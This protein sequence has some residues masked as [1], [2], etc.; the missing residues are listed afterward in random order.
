LEKA[1]NPIRNRILR[2]V[3]IRAGE[4]VPHELNP[5][6]HTDTQRQALE[7][8]YAEI[9]FARSLLAYPLADG[10]LKLIDG[11]LR[12]S[13]NPDQEVDVEVLDVND[14][15]AR[16]LLLAIDPLAQIAGYDA[17][18][19]VQLRKAA[20]ADSAAIT[21]LFQAVAEASRQTGRALKEIKEH[22]ELPEKFYVL[23]DCEDEAHQQELLIRFEKEGLTCHAKVA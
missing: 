9:G 16:T 1:M 5:R 18:L 19:M 11:H 6:V 7:Q 8:L 14:A 21:Y 12:A 2:H 10:R 22:D 15:E 4:L 3:R 20:E 17:D 13:M 23:V